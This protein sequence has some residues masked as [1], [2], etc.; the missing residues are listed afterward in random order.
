MKKYSS[1]FLA[2]V[3]AI[4]MAPGSVQAGSGF[5]V[6]GDLGLNAASGIDTTGRS[7]DRS[8]VCDEYIN[9]RYDEVESSDQSDSSGK[10]YSEYNCTGPRATTWPNE[11]DGGTG[12]LAGA[13]VGYSFAG[14]NPN[15]PLSGF[16]VEMEY[17]Y[18]QSNYDQ[19][20]SV[21][22]GSGQVRGKLEQEIV[23]GIE[24]IGS[25]TSHNLFAN[26]FYDFINTSRF[27]PYVGVGAGF[28]FTDLGYGTVWA[29]NP[30]AS[31]IKTGANL[32]NEQQIRENL[33][34]TSSVAQLTLSDTLFGFQ[35]L[36]GV[37]YALTEAM[38]LG[39]KGRWVKYA[40]FQDD[41]N[42]YMLRSH[43]PNL[44][45]DGSEPVSGGFKTDDIEFFGVSVNLKYHF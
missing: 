38:S 8:S 17:F 39:V 16:R 37:D 5:Y 36:F 4:V 45:K 6:S 34:G 11:F 1:P 23:I 25:I 14:Q 12:V 10:K 33:A 24:R 9:P 21:G 2:F 27:T 13:A 7:N 43:V 15:G 30:D 44:R 18:R 40:S 20:S 28:G 35:A 29:R 32:P 41:V 22:G 31:K 42:V 3:I 26:L 19:T